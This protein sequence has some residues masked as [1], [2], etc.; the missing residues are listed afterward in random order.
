MIFSFLSDRCQ[1]VVKNRNT[2]S[3]NFTKYGI[4][5]GSILGPLFFTLFI[6]DLPNSVEI[7]NLRLYADDIQALTVLEGDWGQFVED[8]NKD[9]EII[10]CWCINNGL[11]I[12]EK[13]IKLSGFQKMKV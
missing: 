6:N 4:P 8:I 5:Q 2:S 10:R 12:N 3:V 7:L 13:K 1:K 11:K 9:I